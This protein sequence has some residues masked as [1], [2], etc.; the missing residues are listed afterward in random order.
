VSHEKT[1]TDYAAVGIARGTDYRNGEPLHFVE[2]EGRTV[3]QTD[4][5]YDACM[6]AAE[7]YHKVAPTTE[8]DAET[9]R[10]LGRITP[11]TIGVGK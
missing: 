5:R 11:G 2:H 10:E 1:C 4:S 7:L 6:F 9:L 8:I 3:F